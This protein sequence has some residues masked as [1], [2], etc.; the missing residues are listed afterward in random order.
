MVE[1]LRKRL[2]YKATHRGMKETEK[3]LG[4]FA[5]CELEELSEDLLDQ[6]DNFLDLS[7]SDILNWVLYPENV[8]DEYDSDIFRL[9]IAFKDKI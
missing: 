5:R 4:G 9:L 6:F 2:I 1:K 8:P 7:D 3:I